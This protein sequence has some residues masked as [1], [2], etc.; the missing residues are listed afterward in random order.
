MEN[1]I[2]MSKV[3]GELERCFTHF[4]KV[5]YK[6]TLPKVV[7]TV[8]SARKQKAW[9]WFSKNAWTDKSERTIPEINIGAES[10]TRPLDELL[11]TLIHEMVHLC[12]WFNDV[13]D[14]G[15]T[16]YHNKHFK[17]GAEA[18]GFEVEKTNHGYNTTKLT[19]MVTKII[20]G[21]KADSKLFAMCRGAYGKGKEKKPGSKL[22]KWFCGCT[23]VRVAVADFDA[24]CNLCGNNFEE[25]E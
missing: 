23:N 25:M 19:P 18:V 14:C 12:N 21:A 24:T 9:G 20:K 8:Q 10:L 3:V 11:G 5:L 6:N 17:A 16:G 4:N 2:P 22:K 1:K 7:I 13:E 15:E